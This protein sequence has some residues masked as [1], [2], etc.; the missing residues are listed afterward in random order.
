MTTKVSIVLDLGFGD[1][2]KGVTVDYLARANPQE[3]LVIRFSGGHQ[4]GHTIQVG[5]FV[6]TFSNFG[7]GTLRG[8][9]TYY[10]KYT[11]IFP[12]GILR[13]YEHIKQFNP[14]LIF[15]PL[16]MVTTP[17]D[18][19]FNRS[20]E[21]LLKHGSCGVG[22]GA[23]IDR[24]LE[25]VK[26]FVKDMAYSW[27]FRQKLQAIKD[28]YQQKTHNTE[29]EEGFKEEIKHID[30]STFIELNQQC[31][32]IYSVENFVTVKNRYGHLIFEGSQGIMLDQEH[33]IFP[34]VT[35]SSTTS[36]NAWAIINQYS[37]TPEKIDIY[38]VTR[39]Y[40]TRHGNGPMSNH[41]KIELQNNEMEANQHNQY[42]GA[43]RIAELDVDL[44]KYALSS[45]VSYHGTDQIN[46]ILVVTCLDQRPKFE[47]DKLLSGLS[48]DFEQVY[49]NN[50]P[51]GMMT[52][53]RQR[54]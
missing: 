29:L 24:N 4:V 38:Y 7:S 5:D 16:T 39:C 30:D 32:Q 18:I 2:G 45:D 31:S 33:G 37:V 43:F 46:K 20:R 10:T 49:I 22:F 11:T 3:S 12:P 44:L 47:L 34:H 17:Y 53:I 35:R 54:V 13:E 8:V 15:D 14:R 28:Y 26:L 19:A 1:S 51:E 48:T 23:T 50:S 6:H 36:Q 41:K 27:V 25:G 21:K 42:Q 9:P 52:I 40:Q